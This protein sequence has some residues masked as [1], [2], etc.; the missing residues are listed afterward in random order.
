MSSPVKDVY[1]IA[2]NLACASGWSYVLFACVSHILAGNEPQ[3]LYDEVEKVLQIV[4]TAALM[5]VGGG[6]VSHVLYIPFPSS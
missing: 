4:Q 5:E 3:A 1:L 2:Y 6:F